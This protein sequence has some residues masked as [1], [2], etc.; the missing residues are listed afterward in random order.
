MTV[1]LNP[2]P[3]LSMVGRSEFSCA[4]TFAGLEVGAETRFR[5]HCQERERGHVSDEAKTLA[6]GRS[7]YRS[8]LRPKLRILV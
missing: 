3:I 4:A 7:G 6:A 1:T 5:G 2:H 8:V